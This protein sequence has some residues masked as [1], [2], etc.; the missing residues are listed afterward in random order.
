[1]WA[2]LKALPALIPLIIELWALIK[3]AFVE[4]PESI[5]ASINEWIQALR[6][7]KGGTLEQKRKAAIDGARKFADLIKRG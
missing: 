2:F 4:S 7:A 5:S 3:P 1:M 6:S